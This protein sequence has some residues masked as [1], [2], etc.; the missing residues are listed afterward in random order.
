MIM[1]QDALL[2]YSAQTWSLQLL[3]IVPAPK[4]KKKNNCY[5]FYIMVL[6]ISEII[7]SI[8]NLFFKAKLLCV[9]VCVCV[10]LLIILYI[11]GPPS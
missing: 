9:C 5:V 10:F 4:D 1:Y 8:F 6:K 11:S 3:L 7:M 2:Y